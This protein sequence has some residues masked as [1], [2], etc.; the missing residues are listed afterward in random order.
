MRYILLSFILVLF[1]CKKGTGNFTIKGIITDNSFNKGLD[2]ATASLYQVT[3]SNSN[4]VFISST[5][6]GSDGSYS[7]VFKR[8]KVEKYILIVSSKLFLEN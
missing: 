4:K 8:D 1:S 5:T 2:G 7:F 6:V 3:S